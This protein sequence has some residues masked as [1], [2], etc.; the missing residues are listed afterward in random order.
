MH[1]IQRLKLEGTDLIVWMIKL[2]KERGKTF[3]CGQRRNIKEKL[4]YVILNYEGE[5][6]KVAKSIE[7]DW[8]DELPDGNVITI[9]S[10]RL[11]RSEMPLKP[12][13]D[14]MEYNRKCKIRK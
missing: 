9:G 12:R 1:A 2:L 11:M 14:G 3:R 5:M 13:F 10:E 7:N 8:M 6:G 4:C